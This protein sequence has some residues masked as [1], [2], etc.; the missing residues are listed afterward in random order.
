MKTKGFIENVETVGLVADDSSYRMK[1]SA[2]STEN[3][4][5]REASG[6]ARVFA[7]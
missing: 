7:F 3:T 1:S 2:H 5:R 4:Q 6:A